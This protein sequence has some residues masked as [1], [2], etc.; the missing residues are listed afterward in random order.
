MDEGVW[1][2]CVP[3]RVGMAWV[4]GVS[5]CGVVVVVV[6]RRA[7]PIITMLPW[8]GA[9]HGCVCWTFPKPNGIESNRT[10]A[11]LIDRLDACVS[12]DRFDSIDGG[13]NTQHSTAPHTTLHGSGVKCHTTHN[14]Q[15]RP[16]AVGAKV[17]ARWFA[18]C[19]TP[20]RV[21]RPHLASLP[22]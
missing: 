19:S 11:H 20:P 2:L 7:R 12:I 10:G 9:V 13:E 22:L 15:M 6:S 14:G 8:C 4:G 1:C 18:A 5:Q 21:R 16:P 3:G 17:W